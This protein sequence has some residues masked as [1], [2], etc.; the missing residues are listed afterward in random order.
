M[1]E[2]FG[3]GAAYPTSGSIANFY[4]YPETMFE[5]GSGRQRAVSG[6][7]KAVALWLLLAHT[8]F[9]KDLQ[10][11]P[12]K[13]E[14]SAEARECRLVANSG[15]LDQTASRCRDMVYAL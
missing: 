8:G 7:Q 10:L 13:L 9:W 4:P 1:T 14:L 12:H 15:I 3:L 6:L 5:W 11:T 2:L